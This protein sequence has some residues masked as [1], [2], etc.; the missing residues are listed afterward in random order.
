MCVCVYE[1]ESEVERERER[2]AYFPVGLL[3]RLCMFVVISIVKSTNI[4]CACNILLVHFASS[5]CF[6]NRAESKKNEI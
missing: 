1:R 6:A 2:L 4:G 5:F 3:V